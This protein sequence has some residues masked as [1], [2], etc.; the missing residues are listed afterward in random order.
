M[1]KNIGICF[2]GYCPMHQGHLDC[3]MRAKKE[4]DIVY[5]VVCGYTNEPRGIEL[6]LDIKQRKRLIK[7]FF[8]D[9]EIIRV[10]DANDTELGIDESMSEHN[11]KVWTD[12][13][14]KMVV[15]NVMK[16]GDSWPFTPDDDIQAFDLKLTFYVGEQFYVES[17]T[18]LHYN[19]VLVGYDSNSPSN[20]SNDISATYIRQRPQLYWDKI[21]PTFKPKLTKKILVLGTASEGKSTL[22]KDIGNYFQIPYTTE[23]GR[24]YMEKHA[25]LDPDITVN[26]FIE[27][28]IGQRQ[29]YFD[30]LNSDKNKGVIISDTDNLVT[31]MYAKAYTEDKNMQIT[32]DEYCYILLPLA[33]SLQTNVDWDV[34]YLI[35]PHNA[36]VDDGTR[37]MNQSSME[38]RMKNYKILLRLLEDFDLLDKVIELNGSYMD[39]FNY[40]K[41]YINSLYEKA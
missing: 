17:L 20:R 29:Y 37:Y 14:K 41:S 6:G 38:E 22:V 13:V 2:G 3:I 21:I 25:M 10:I 9:D 5:V 15:H 35:K 39:H 34:I 40:V 30:A 12:H 8:K 33:K 31:L 28:L 26:D 16:H 19:V 32:H 23:F 4:N 7:E 27:F 11:W 36:F 1:S 24:D 18:K